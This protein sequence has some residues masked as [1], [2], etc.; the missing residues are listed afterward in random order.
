[1][2][3]MTFS[4]SA[5]CFTTNMAVKCNATDYALDFPKAAAAVESSFYGDNCLTSANFNEEAIDLH[6]ELMHHIKPDY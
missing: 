1:M 2:T 6:Q 4:L 3:R 5:S